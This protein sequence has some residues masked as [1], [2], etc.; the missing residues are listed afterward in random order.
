MVAVPPLMPLTRPVNSP[1][2]AT[3]VLLLVQN[4]PVAVVD[5]VPVLPAHRLAGPLMVPALGSGVTVTVEV[6]WQAP[7]E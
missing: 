5:R 1:T 6:T 4:P 7:I 3:E 2:V